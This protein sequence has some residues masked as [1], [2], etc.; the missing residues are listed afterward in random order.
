MSHVRMDENGARALAIAALKERQAEYVECVGSVYLEKIGTKR[1][2]NLRRGWCF[3]FRIPWAL[4]PPDFR[5]IVTDPD[6]N[7]EFP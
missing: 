4:D 3:L 1:F 2:G 6:G 5:V 7:V